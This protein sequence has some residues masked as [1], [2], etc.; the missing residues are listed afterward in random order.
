MPRRHILTERQ[1]SALF[2]LPKDELSLLR[3][4][5]LGDDDLAHIQERR[6]PDNRLGFALQLCALRYPGRAL[7]PGEVIP[8]EVLSFIGAQLGVPADA[9]LTYAA[10]RQTRQEH[11]EALR[12]IY[13]YKTFAG[14]GARDLRDWLFGQAEDARSNEDIAQRLVARC[15]ETLT[16]LPATSTIERLCADALVAAERQIE[17]RIAERLDDVGRERL[18]G[19]LTELLDANISR[20][21]WLRQFEVGNNS[22]AANRLL[23]RLE[24]LRGL[25]LDPQVL[26]GIPPHRIARLRRQGERYFTD[27]LR[28]ISSDRRWAI[29]AVCAVEWEAMIADTMVETHDRIVGKTWR[30]AKRLCDERIAGSKAAVTATLRAFTALGSSLLEARNDGVP[31]E[32]AVA[33][34]AEWG[35]LEQLVATGAQLSNTLADD[36][37]AHVGQGY[38]RFRRYAP[39]MLR[40]LKLKGALVALPLIAAAKA[41]GEMQASS[42]ATDSFLRPNSK[43]HRHLRAQDQGDNRLRE[44]AVLFHLRDALRSIASVK[45]V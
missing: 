13:G 7:T 23:D 1:R 33:K 30:E 5:T 12:E 24:F 26:A 32:M 9:L 41:I 27:G 40:C 42:S 25:N 37:L 28:D 15:R 38:H 11:M 34:L 22:A 21:I 35:R 16:I 43:W 17:T 31:L 20:F 29:L 4:Y 39:R 44:V 45:L 6:R 2:D 8:Q 10:R 3:Y 36:P 14:R 19:L 18:D